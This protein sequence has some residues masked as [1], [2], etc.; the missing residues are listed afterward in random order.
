MGESS[1]RASWNKVRYR[2]LESMEGNRR[3]PR[4]HT[5]HG[6]V[7]GVQG[8]SEGKGEKRERCVLNK[9]V[10]GEELLEN[11]REVKRRDWN[12]NVFTRPSGQREN[13]ETVISCRGPGPAIKL[14]LIHI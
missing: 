7:W 2:N 12:E 13:V 4:R 10:A 14:S 6:E 1:E 5:V 11:L 3:K 9:K 8:K